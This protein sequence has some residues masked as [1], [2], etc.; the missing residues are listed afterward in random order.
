MTDRMMR[1]L[2]CA[3]AGWVR[4][5][6]HSRI[7][8]VRSVDRDLQLVVTRT[9]LLATDVMDV[10]IQA[11]DSSQLPEWHEGAHIDLVLPSGKV[12]QYSLCGDRSDRTSYRIAVRRLAV[13][14][15]GSVE[16]HTLTPGTAVVVRGP[17]NAFPFAYPHLAKHH[18]DDVAFVAGG[19]GITALLPMVRAASEAGVTWR[20][21][22]VG[23]DE[24][25]MPFLD[26]LARLTGG[27][28]RVLHGEPAIE[29]ILAGVDE[30]TSVYFC[31][32][33]GFLDAVSADLAT[34][35]HAG[36][37]FERFVPPPVVGGSPFTVRLAISELDVEVPADRSALAAIRD[38]I[39]EV[40]YSCQQGFCGT[41]R[42]GVVRGTPERRGT[43]EFLADENS[44]LVSVDRSHDPDLTIDL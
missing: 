36:F 41:C 11:P 31:G 26:D 17:H 34:R 2:D 16:V 19:I 15:G 5:A 3:V 27:E 9:E 22:Y 12:R 28:L 21:S 13:G 37:H 20:L 44:M 30:R 1:F 25:T 38:V 18:I 4:A 8:T 14:G 10:T 39:P 29:D 6:A 33:P 23:R 35:P 40:P 7:R 42:V 43:A 32:P 24:A